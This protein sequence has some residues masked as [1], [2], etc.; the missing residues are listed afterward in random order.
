MENY[1]YIEHHGVKGMKWGVRRYRQLRKEGAK[2]QRKQTMNKRMMDGNKD[3]TSFT[4]KS[5]KGRSESLE[6]RKAKDAELEKQ[7]KQKVK[8][9]GD[10]AKKADLSMAVRRKTELGKRVVKSY[11]TNNTIIGNN[12]VYSNKKITAKDE[13]DRHAFGNYSRSMD[14]DLYWGKMKKKKVK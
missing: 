12:S 11:A 5:S 3:F 1:D 8:E 7:Y 14:R 10:V 13:F 2:I 6:K 9:A 4:G